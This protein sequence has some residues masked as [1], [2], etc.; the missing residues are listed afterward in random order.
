MECCH[1]VAYDIYFNISFE[2]E[3]YQNFFFFML[4]VK[5]DSVSYDYELNISD[6]YF[7]NN[8]FFLLLCHIQDSV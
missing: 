2:N 3:I 1:S 5:L 6:S 8:L 7:I 4:K